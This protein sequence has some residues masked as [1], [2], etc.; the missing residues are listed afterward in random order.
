MKTAIL[1]SP[2]MHGPEIERLQKLLKG[3][4]WYHGAI[5]G[6]YGEQTAQ[7]V[8]RGKHYIGVAKPDHIA[9][10]LFVSYLTG[11]RK[12]TAAM[13]KLAAKRAQTA[14]KLVTKKQRVVQIALS[15]LG[16]T[17]NP[18]NSNTSKFSKWYMNDAD[19][20]TVEHPGPPWC[21][22]FVTWVECHVDI[23][24]KAFM[25][26]VRWAYCPFIVSAARA[27]QWFLTIARGPADAVLALFDWQNNGVA[28]HIG[29]CA[30]EATI[31][32]FAP[33][34]LAAAI[35]EFGPLGP[36]DFWC[37]EGNT[38]VGNDSNGG[39]TM[40]RKRNRSQVQVFVSVGA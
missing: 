39:M 19:G 8:F 18:P 31:K 10:D 17:E 14:K 28:D 32:R 15:Q 25:K 13:V 2:P 33:Q 35:A 38:A 21:A 16:Q 3:K 1:T 27:G 23:L 30:L 24:S 6:D 9:G 34:A 11:K 12:P 22:I 36:G 4:G 7:A 29:I 20:W 5:D 37:I 40:L 26:G